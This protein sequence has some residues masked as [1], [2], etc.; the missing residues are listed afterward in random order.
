[1]RNLL[2][3]VFLFASCAYGTNLPNMVVVIL[4]TN[5]TSMTLTNSGTGTANTTLRCSPGSGQR[6][7]FAITPGVD[8]PPRSD[9][10]FTPCA[11]PCTQTVNMNLGTAY[12]WKSKANSGG[13]RVTEWSQRSKLPTVPLPCVAPGSWTV[14]IYMV[15]QD[16]LQKCVQVTISGTPPSGVVMYNRIYNHNYERRGI[17]TASSATA[18]DGKASVRVNSG[19]WI[20]I[21][22]ATVTEIDQQHYYNDSRGVTP[23]IGGAAHT[24]MVTVPIPDGLLVTGTNSIEYRFNGTDGITSGYYIL[25][26]AFLTTAL[27]MDQVLVASG[28]G[29]YQTTSSNTLATNDWVLIY[30]APDIFGGLSGNRQITRVDA[31]HFNAVNCPA[32]MNMLA[33]ACSIPDGTYAP[34]S[35]QNTYIDEINMNPVVPPGMWVAKRLNAPAAEDSPS[36]FTAPG[37]ADATAGGVL[38]HARG[39]GMPGPISAYFDYQSSVACTD[40]HDKNLRD[41]AYFRFPNEVIKARTVFHG[42]TEA[43]GDQI[44]AYV[45]SLSVTTGD[46]CRTWNPPYNP[47][48]GLD[49]GNV[50]LWGCGTG[51]DGLLNYGNDAVR[52]LDPAADGATFLATG[53]MNH[54]QVPI[55]R[56]APD[57][58]HWL[59]RIHPSDVPTSLFPAFFSSTLY[60]GYQDLVTCMA[61]GT[62]AGYGACGGDAGSFGLDW[63]SK[64]FSSSIGYKVNFARF[65]DPGRGNGM[66]GETMAAAQY[67]SIW[68]MATHSMYLWADM[69]SFELNKFGGFEDMADQIITTVYGAQTLDL[70]AR[71]WG[72]FNRMTYICGPHI[73]LVGNKANYDQ[74]QASHLYMSDMKYQTGG[75]LNTGNR[76]QGGPS[77]EPVD[78]NY[79]VDYGVGEGAMRPDG[80]LTAIFFIPNLQASLGEAASQLSARVISP[81][82]W[83]NYNMARNYSWMTTADITAFLTKMK[84][85]FLSAMNYY[86]GGGDCAS[87]SK[88]AWQSYAATGDHFSTT[89]NGWS[90][91]GTGPFLADGVA[92]MFGPLTYFNAI[93]SGE[94]I[95][96]KNWANASDFSGTHDYS[97]DISAGAS[98]VL[99]VSG[100]T[101]TWVSGDDFTNMA[102]HG[103]GTPAVSSYLAIGSTRYQITAHASNT[104]ITL[105]G[106]PPSGTNAYN[107]CLLTEPNS[108]GASWPKCGNIP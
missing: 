75:W 92:A 31:T 33:A 42:F 38:A 16:G 14:P 103:S 73:A 79:T 4:D 94:R 61:A 28:S 100:N 108:N 13:T 58:N 21:N 20:N 88:T 17:G 64:L 30:G 97:V 47:G 43:Q 104:S 65:W 55:T 59:P 76:H 49:A 106:S 52:Y 60:A 62:K 63:T 6:C 32:T 77:T 102:V 22:N 46:P 89:Q 80:P 19:A 71:G 74:T 81:V 8:I 69:K 37:G 29:R 56:Q 2:A 40:C 82:Y 48:K 27:A 12:V 96:I 11:D 39:M 78:S 41:L 101:A 83:L 99:S 50:A 54:R 35:R 26:F 1:M 86:C 67:P 85:A 9:T 95:L 105:S 36:G 84:N 53:L 93:T 98:G 5:V 3:V 68:P 107:R 66:T 45:R 18:Y 15:G 90:M 25:D 91:P 87:G 51:I 23:W 70:Y 10:T 24:L 72:R 44:A 7:I 34:P 57:W